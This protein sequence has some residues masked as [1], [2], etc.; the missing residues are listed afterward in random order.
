MKGKLIVWCFFVG[1]MF[2]IPLGIIGLIKRNTAIGQG[3]I[4]PRIHTEA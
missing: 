3:E 4:D 2:G 1:I